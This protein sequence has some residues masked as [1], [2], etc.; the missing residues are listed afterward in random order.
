[1]TDQVGARYGIPE[2]LTTFY[3]K[4]CFLLLTLQCV[5]VKWR[6]LRRVQTWSSLQKWSVV[7]RKGPLKV[8]VKV[9]VVDLGCVAG[10]TG[11]GY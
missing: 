11:A 4:L 8:V 2:Q 3:N 7:A 9:T 10:E 1:M 6:S 5:N